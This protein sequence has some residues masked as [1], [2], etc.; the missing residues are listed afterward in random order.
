MSVPGRAATS[1][2]ESTPGQEPRKPGLVLPRVGLAFAGLFVVSGACGL[3]YEVVWSRLL[4]HVFGVSAF[5]ISTV[6]ASFM[7]GMALGA[8]LLGRSADRMRRPLRLFAALEAGIGLYA[9]VLPVLLAGVERLYGWIFPVLPDLFWPRSVVRFVLCLGVLLVPTVLMGGTLPAL[10]RGLLGRQ[11][12][13]GLGI[14]LLYF[15]NTLGAALGC[16]LAGFVLVPQLGLRATT[17]LAAAFNGLVAAT[18]VLLDRGPVGD[19]SVGAVDAPVG[20]RGPALSRHWPLA[21]AFGSGFA[22]LAFEIVWFRVLILVFGSTVYSFS[23][24]LSVFLLGLALGAIL[25]GSIADRVPSPVRLLAMTQLAVAVF[26]LLGSLA[27]DQLPGLFLHVF[28]GMGFDYEGINRAKLGLSFLTLFA[29]ALAF[30]GTFPAAVRAWERAGGTGSRIGGVYAWN[31]LGAIAGSFAAGFVLV[32]WIGSERTLALIVEIALVLTFGSLLAEPGRLRVRWAVPTGLAV[33]GLAA[34]LAFAPD[35]DWSV[36]NAGVFANPARYFDERGQVALEPVLRGQQLVSRVE[37]YNS[38]IACLRGPSTKFLNVNGSTVASDQYEDML[39]QRILGHLPVLLH[40][41]PVRRVCIVGFGAGVTAGAAGLSEIGE[42]TAVELEPGVVAAV[43]YFEREN[44]R[45]LEHPRLHLVIDDARNLLRLTDRE[46]DVISSSPNFPWMTGAGSLYAREFLELA[47]DRLAPGGLVAQLVPIVRLLSRDVKTIVGTFSEAFPHVRVFAMGSVIVLLGSR[48]PFPA[49]DVG[50]LEARWSRPLVAESLAEVGFRGPRELLA[51]Y[52]FDE[53]EARAYASGA[54]RNT[55]D[56]PAVEFFAPEGFFSEDSVRANLLELLAAAPPAEERGRRL[57]LAG[58]DLSSFLILASAHREAF[59]ALCE[60]WEGKTRQ[61]MDRVLPVAES[62]HRYARYL[63]AN[64]LRRAGSDLARG[65]DYDLAGVQF[66]AAVRY[67]PDHLDG[68]LGLGE[69]RLLLGQTAEARPSLEAAVDRFPDSAVAAA[70]LGWLELIEGHLD[71]AELLLRRAG[72]LA[73]DTSETFVLLGNLFLARGAAERAL[74]AYR[75]A[76]DCPDATEAAF[77]GTVEVHLARGQAPEALAAARAAT[78]R[79]P[80]SP[81]T[82]RLLER[83]GVAAGEAGEAE[84]A[85]QRLR[86]LGIDPDTRPA[87]N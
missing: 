85:R 68:L 16:Y 2:S 73:P 65:G 46:F 26:A 47:R 3:A 84:I 28:R 41:S 55:D 62:G 74:E 7:G 6:L 35:W 76:Q 22:A 27:V 75:R 1:E 24:M 31:T 67:E 39:H 64:V 63:A 83:A 37:G 30:G 80:G 40:A 71:R 29:P 60:F 77:E 78:A 10:G 9:L 11:E 66:E 58:E 70:R 25:V 21:V 86:E 44:R 20:S 45:V 42:L 14:G 57:G 12:Q 51:T 13:V 48:D 4:H 82:W 38:T 36:L 43:K 15:V 72:E 61:A 59:V 69:A 50:G 23:A 18:A 17:L 52:L 49:V 34:V 33:V 56:R 5:A 79:L 53:T 19:A 81:R 54:A 87:A 32:P 8:A